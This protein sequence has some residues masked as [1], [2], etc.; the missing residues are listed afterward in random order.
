VTDLDAYADLH[1]IGTGGLGDVY[2]A[3]STSTG[4]TVAI[5]ILRDVSDSSSWH[6][7]RRELTA[8]EELADHPNVIAAVE[9]VDGPTGPALV[10]EYAPGGSIARLL[11]RRGGRLSVAE[12]V[13]VG[14]QA[15]AGLVAAH[16]RGIVHRDVKPQNLLIDEYGH[17][18]LC[19]FGIARLTRS[20]EFR[21][22]T[23]ALSTRYASPEDLDEEADLTAASDV[24]SLGAT[25]LH[26]VSGSPPTLRDRLAPWA[27][28]ADGNPE[29]A[30]TEAIIAACLHPDPIE[31]PSAR[32]AMERLNVV[33]WTLPH[34]CRSLP[35]DEDSAQSA[36]DDEAWATFAEG[37][38]DGADSTSPTVLLDDRP[39][40]APTPR[41]VTKRSRRRWPLMVVAVVLASTVGI[42]VASTGSRGGIAVTSATTAAPRS[43]FATTTT[44]WTA[45]T[46]IARPSQGQARVASVPSPMPR[47][48]LDLVSSVWPFGEVGHCLVQ[49]NGLDE[50]M[51][52]DCGEPHDFQ[53]FVV[54][55]LDDV[56]TGSTV[57]QLALATDRACR[58]GFEAF[59]GVD[60]TESSLRIAATRPSETSW[61]DGDRR[62]Q[63]LLASPDGLLVGDAGDSAS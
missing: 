59:V 17:V 16:E 55:E 4:R 34:R 8:L 38:A 10:M 53:R 30:A 63:C 12:T 13:F 15:A 54:G 9:L 52:V 36:D 58:A 62:F 48:D 61:A 41:P 56:E 19:D 45:E 28:G 14:R 47:H 27:P 22:C 43:T 24:Y 20:D 33:D 60:P 40:V 44:I 31:R 29:R 50:L 57:E 23:S 51:P 21:R 32:D 5:K 11:A 35:I 42:V 39:L 6:R 2:R 1:Q 18:K 49:V 37:L 25:L 26:L 46:G 3:T 7:A